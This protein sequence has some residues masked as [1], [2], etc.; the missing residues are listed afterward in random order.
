LI[1]LLIVNIDRT[2]DDNKYKMG[3]SLSTPNS[4]NNQIWKFGDDLNEQYSIY[5]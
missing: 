1:E 2:I 5:K 4:L 3:S